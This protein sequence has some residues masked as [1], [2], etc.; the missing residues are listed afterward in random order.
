MAVG[1]EF[2]GR[3]YY[4]ILVAVIYRGSI[5]QRT[6][7]YVIFLYELSV[8]EFIQS[9]LSACEH[10]VFVFRVNIARYEVYESVSGLSGNVVFV[11][12]PVFSVIYLQAGFAF[13]GGQ[14]V[15]RIQFV[16]GKT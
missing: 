4:I 5:F 2:Y 9:G 14:S 1:I 16:S 13:R 10:V 7:V 8:S 15:C 6:V 12:G 11:Y 3:H